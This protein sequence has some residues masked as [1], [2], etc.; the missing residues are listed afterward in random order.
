MKRSYPKLGLL[1]SESPIS[2]AVMREVGAHGVPIVAI[3]RDADS[4]LKHSRYATQAVHRP[5]GALASWLPQLA[6]KLR[7][8]AVMAIGESD[9]VELAELKQCSHA[10]QIAAPDPDTLDLVLDKSALLAKAESLGLT[11]PWSL[12]P[13]QPD[14]ADF[15][16]A[17]VSFPLIAKWSN[18]LEIQPHLEAA[19]IAFEKVRYFQTMDEVEAY[20]TSLAPLG[21]WPLFQE[22]CPGYGLGQMFHLADGEVT[23]RFQHRRL[24]E[25][26]LTGGVSSFCQAVP[27]SEHTELRALSE[28]LL[29]ELKWSGPAMVEYR[30]DPQT[31][32]ARLMEINGRFWGSLPL[33]T[34]AGVH[35]AWE[36]Y[37][38][39][40]LQSPEAHG[41]PEYPPC[42]ARY[43]APELKNLRDVTLGRQPAKA[44]ASF[45]FRFL[46]DFFDRSVH[47]YLFSR[48]DPKPFFFDIRN[49]LK[50]SGT[51]R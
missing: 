8:E 48:R 26:P 2:L 44:K 38:H 18:P 25:W 10:F 17:N 34:A 31:G 45:L 39:A 16:A 33:A 7:I 51:G 4:F 46:S 35:F 49:A 3:T 14:S 20:L 13:E 15:K 1:C 43:M 12:Q 6:K 21:R 47:Y 28:T 22:Y 23:L 29:R 19:G 5:K 36:T 24:R 32:I 37:R 9:L 40:F 11:V 50:R 27:L 41:Q 30:F 42:K